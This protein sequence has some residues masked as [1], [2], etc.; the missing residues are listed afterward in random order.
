MKIQY[1]FNLFCQNS[2]NLTLLATNPQ[3]APNTFLYFKIILFY[4]PYTIII[5]PQITIIF[6]RQISHIWPF[7]PENQPQNCPKNPV[8]KR[9]VQTLKFYTFFLKKNKK[10]WK[11]GSKIDPKIAKNG[12]QLRASKSDIWGFLSL[13]FSGKW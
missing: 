2:P 9:L 1:F 5:L 13:F 4:I 12:R 8:Y 6:V 11:K 10:R 3:I 7:F